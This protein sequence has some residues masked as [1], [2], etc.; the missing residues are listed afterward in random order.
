MD[1]SKGTYFR[2]HRV[3]LVGWHW[4]D[5][6]SRQSGTRLQSG[7]LRPTREIGPEREVQG[8]GLRSA[9]Q[10]IVGQHTYKYYFNL[11]LPC[12]LRGGKSPRLPR[13]PRLPPFLTCM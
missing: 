9:H 2:S 3:L 10:D 5:G 4:R 13:L 6:R 12:N 8:G 11:Y 7:G 1:D